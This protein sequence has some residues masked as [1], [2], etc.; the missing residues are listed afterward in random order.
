MKE[1]KRGCFFIE[2]QC[3]SVHMMNLYRLIQVAL[4]IF[5]Y[6]CHFLYT[7]NH[8]NTLRRLCKN[9]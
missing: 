7:Q 3:T 5:N 6:I 1:N 2:T 8:A 9:E 4:L